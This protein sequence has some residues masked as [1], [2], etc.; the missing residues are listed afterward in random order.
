MWRFNIKIITSFFLF[1]LSLVLAVNSAVLSDL[2]EEWWSVGPY[3]HGL[4]GLVLTLYIFWT[5]KEVFTFQQGNVFPLLLL[6]AVSLLLLLSSLASIGQLQILSLFLVILV[7][8]F[9]FFGFQIIS[10]LLLPLAMLFLILPIWNLL[11]I[12]LRDIS[13]WISFHSVNLLG[14]EII[15]QGYKLITPSGN[16]IVAEACSGL[17]FF[18][19]SALYAVFVAQVNKFSRQVTII[20]FLFAVMIAIIANWIRIIVIII[21]GSQTAMQHF[22]VQEHLTFGW[23]VFAVCFL[24]VIIAGNVY[25]IENMPDN[26]NQTEAVKRP[27]KI[28][29]WYFLA[30]SAITLLFAVATLWFPVRFDP[31]YTF[32][33]PK[34]PTYTQLT[35]NSAFSQNW[36][37]VSHG[38]TSE[39]FNYFLQ[40]SDLLQVYLASY[41]KQQQG[42]EMIFIKNTLFDKND[43]FNVRQQKAQLNSTSL[44]QVNLI[45]LSKN[46]HDSRLIAYW[47]FVDGQFIADKKYAKLYEMK[48]TIKGQPG[49]T[50]IAIAFD[51][52]NKDENKAIKK[53]TDFVTIFSRQSLN[54][55]KSI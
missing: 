55:N 44:K 18:L 4:L 8:L 11:Q 35:E 40:G 12:P 3:N 19:T 31:K 2:M 29:T 9:S 42:K 21:V 43:W 24:P 26:V 48:A 37:P 1:N 51:Y 41:V 52:D 53:I 15:R 47:Y 27:E 17:G 49:A 5:K 32:T 36:H 13:T 22:I 16:F 34:I 54:I 25:L 10:K 14:F 45:T 20:Y 28:K 6:S 23:F 33:L 39:E 50:L 46:N 30:I 7:L 38:A